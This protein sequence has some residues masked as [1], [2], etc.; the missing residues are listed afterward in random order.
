[1]IGQ[2]GQ[3]DQQ[4]HR[5]PQLLMGV[6]TQPDHAR[7]VGSVSAMTNMDCPVEDTGAVT[8][9]GS[10]IIISVEDNDGSKES[11]STPRAPTYG[12]TD[13]VIHAIDRDDGEKYIVVA[14]RDSLQVLRVGSVVEKADLTIEPDAENYLAQNGDP[15]TGLIGTNLRFATLGDR[16]LIANT[17]VPTGVLDGSTYTITDTFETYAD[18]VARQGVV[19]EY[20]KVEND[21]TADGATRYYRYRGVADGNSEPSTRATAR[22]P[23]FAVNNVSPWT[24]N[25]RGPN[26]FSLSS[27]Y[28]DTTS[29]GL[30][31]GF[32]VACGRSDLSLSGVS[33]DHT[34]AASGERLLTATG[35]GFAT[36]V[37]NEWIEIT[38]STSFTNA[39][40]T[41][42]QTSDV[43]PGWY[44]VEEKV[45]DN[46]I[47]L[48]S[49]QTGAASV[50]DTV[51]IGRVAA[52]F[53][54]RLPRN[55]EAR[56]LA[57]LAPMLL[58]DIDEVPDSIGLKQASPGGQTIAAPAGIS[59]IYTE[60][61]NTGN[62]I[63]ADRDETARFGYFTLTSPYGGEASEI[64]W[65]RGPDAAT[66]PGPDSISP[67]TTTNYSLA[68][69]IEVPI[70]RNG[71]IVGFGT[72]EIF[73]LPDATAGVYTQAT[74]KLSGFPNEVSLLDASTAASD[75][76]NFFYVDDVIEVD[77]AAGTQYQPVS[78]TSSSD[79][80][81]VSTSDHTLPGSDE[82]GRAFAYHIPKPFYLPMAEH[83]A[84]SGPEFAVADDTDNVS[85]WE[86]VPPPGGRASI[87]DPRRMPVEM[88]RVS[89]SD[90]AGTRSGFIIRPVSWGS[91]TIGTISN[92]PAPRLFRDA[93]PITEMAFHRGRLCL[94]GGDQVALSGAEDYYNFF[95][96]NVDEL[97]DSDR[98]GLTAAGRRKCNILSSAQTDDA[99]LIFTDGRAQ[100]RLASTGPLTPT[101]AE[102]RQVLSYDTP[103]VRPV[104]HG[105]IIH[106]I[107]THN[108]AP[109]KMR[110]FRFYEDFSAND[111]QDI[112]GHYRGDL[113]NEIQSMAGFLNNGMTVLLEKES[114]KVGSTTL[115]VHRMT[116]IGERMEQSAWAAWDLAHGRH[117]SDIVSM[118]GNLYMLTSDAN[119]A[120]AYIEGIPFDPQSSLSNVSVIDTAGA[121]TT[122]PDEPEP[123]L[124]WKTTAVFP[125]YSV[126]FTDFTVNEDLGGG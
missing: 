68:D 109:V 106:F 91:R 11:G 116:Y 8:R 66:I 71:G 6:N 125:P 86:S 122:P 36:V 47:R 72:T 45:D 43:A 78:A 119:G 7:P 96:T 69:T 53:E 87:L 113:P 67:S 97:L 104:E 23:Y 98:I 26:P 120:N 37:A 50:D 1:M 29:G 115:H 100:F 118:D 5:V 59:L 56:T 61:D 2:Q 88:V 76:S 58:G 112:S 101:N 16:T 15:S 77:F 84:G 54:G 89:R 99:L 52:E 24:Q 73:D 41:G 40:A 35:D 60:E 110:Q 20:Y 107:T 31:A 3:Q 12:H 83:T 114:G 102:L 42:N 39:T 28:T 103:D 25:E 27:T 105:F 74:S 57:D 108:N 117:I 81:V 10:K 65:V 9:A 90:D 55:P 18:M 48:Y 79:V 33:Y 85:L 30:N 14:G 44:Q 126:V 22:F 95:R 94:M 19:G 111:A 121:G 80:T 62:A 49:G 17:T 64:L 75:P 70:R 124:T 51:T 92:N 93:N 21:E 34:G 63:Y 32:R 123:T 38:A 82:S 13:G 46:N 4:T